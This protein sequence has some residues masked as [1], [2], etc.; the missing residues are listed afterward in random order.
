MSYLSC[1]K[2]WFKDLCICTLE[3]QEGVKVMLN[4]Q[5]SVMSI[6]RVVVLYV[7]G[8][9][10]GMENIKMKTFFQESFPEKFQ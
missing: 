1:N 4:R 3:K 5:M 7:E 10:K 2:I 8:Y 9:H 6:Q